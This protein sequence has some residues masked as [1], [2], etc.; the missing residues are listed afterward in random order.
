MSTTLVAVTGNTYPVRD[1]LKALGG[2]W[3]GRDQPGP[4]DRLEEARAIVAAAGPDKRKGCGT[5]RP[6]TCAGCGRR[7]NY[8]RYCGKCE[9]G[10]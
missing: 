6:R 5:F 9:F 2:R 3:D 10:R 4:A 1:R 7:I 8:G